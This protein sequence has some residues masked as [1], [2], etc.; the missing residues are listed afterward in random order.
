MI[1]I[2]NKYI[3]DSP[4]LTI[5]KEIRS[6]TSVL[7]DTY[8]R[9]IKSSSTNALVTCPFHK[10]HNEK[11]P[12]CSVFLTDH[13]S[14]WRAGQYHCFACNATGDLSDLVAA[15]F[16]EDKRF[17]EEWLIER[18]GDVLVQQEEILPE[19]TLDAPK[20]ETGK[21]LDESCLTAFDYY[22]PYMWKRKL[23]QDVVD[24]FRIGYDPSR[25]AITFPVYDEKH[26]LVMVTARSTKTKR[27]WI[28]R[29]VDK[30]VYL[31][32]DL[33]ERGS[34]TAFVCESQINALYLRTFNYPSIGLFGT[35]SEKQYEILRK[36]GIRNYVL[37]FDGDEA[38]Q[39]GA[40]RFRKNM[41]KDV[42]ITEV[43]LPAGKDVN[44]LTKE[45]I[46][47]YYNLS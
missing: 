23:T 20:V 14:G 16:N 30:P 43:R 22:H 31:L 34:D 35:G 15:C 7:G 21:F 47:H 24:R 19:I 42:F 32:Y 39:K 41:P 2:K 18:Y 26:R 44:D 9:D 45:E 40:M 37:F 28:P 3:I 46:D 11:K 12:A 33:L 25:D 8:L 5:L 13:D 27:F 4:V 29:D 38:G 1:K 10:N 17:G 6:E 36:C